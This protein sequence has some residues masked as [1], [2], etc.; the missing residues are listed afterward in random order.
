MSYEILS[1][2]PTY[3]SKPTVFDWQPEGSKMEALKALLSQSKSK[4]MP[5]PEYT[6]L[7]VPINNV[8]TIVSAQ[9]MA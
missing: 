3:S 5:S 1:E 6:N 9:L 2:R 4:E 8:L 7:V